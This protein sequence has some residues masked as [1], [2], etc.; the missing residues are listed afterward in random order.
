MSSAERIFPAYD[1]H[2][3]H[4]DRRDQEEVNKPAHRVDTDD[5]EKPEDK[6][7]DR[8]GDEHM[9]FIVD[10]INKE[11]DYLR[12]RFL[13]GTFPPA[14]RAC[15]KPMAI[16]CFR[17]VTF[18]PPLERSLP[19]L[20]SWSA[21]PTFCFAFAPYFAIRNGLYERITDLH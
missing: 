18:L 8:Y 3:E 11:R 12:E 16:A 6:E 19:R 17:L 7:D 2:K 10:L 9:P 21:F 14:R 15:D 20:R 13:G 5:T 4:D 1:A